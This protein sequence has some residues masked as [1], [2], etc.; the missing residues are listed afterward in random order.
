MVTSDTFALFTSLAVTTNYFGR[1]RGESATEAGDYSE[2]VSFVTTAS[3]TGVVPRNDTPQDYTLEQNYPN[4]FNPST[5]IQFALLEGGYTTLRI[6]N[7][8]GEEVTLL[9]SEFVGPGRHNIVW[10]AEGVPSGV[11]LC[12]LRSGGYR[13]AIRMVLLK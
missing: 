10:R 4:P 2:P 8:L 11:Y 7:P 6:L 9:L 5:T 3:G 12:E 1:V 13:Q